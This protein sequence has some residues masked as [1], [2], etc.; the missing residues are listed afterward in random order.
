MAD[1]FEYLKWR[2]DLT[3]TQDPPNA[4]D[5]LIFSALSYLR[6][7]G[8]VKAEP[9][10]PL[11]LR[12][13]ADAFFALPDYKERIRVEKDLELLLAAAESV[14]FGFTRLC[15]YRDLLIPEKQ[16]QFAAVTFL[17]DD[18]SAFLAFRG[19]DYSLVGWKE[20]FNMS[21]QQTIPAQRLALQY[22]REI[23]A[24][25]T[26]P[27]RLGGHS[28]GGNLAVFAAA[29]SAPMV[30][31]RIMQ[32]F[33]HDGPGFTEYMMGDPGY[34][35]MVPR[36]KTYIPQSSVIGMLLEHE[37]PYTIV[38]SKQIGLLQHDFYSW[39]LI[40]RNFVTMEEITD[41]SRFLNQTIKTWLTDMSIAQ[42]NEVVDAVYELLTISDAEDVF[43]LLHPRHVANYIKA[44]GSDS[45]LRRILSGEFQAFLEAAKKTQLQLTQGDASG[46]KDSLLP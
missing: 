10:S 45:K 5:A 27:L 33:N 31:K 21:F 14:R 12:A 44:L 35:A 20:D 43:D 36:I 37:E 17:L 23:A 24:E 26:V 9:G 3:F 30:Q 25:Y 38:K 16:T 15:G 34:I 29:R 39:E 7:G 11:P 42:R 40:G 1:L 2:G 32:V 46:Q 28:K 13:A 41:D 22:T 19:T 6:F 8:K 18:G 4:V